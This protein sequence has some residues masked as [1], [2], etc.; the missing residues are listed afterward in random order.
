[1]KWRSGIKHDCSHVMELRRNGADEFQNGLKEIINLEPENLYPMLKSSDLLQDDPIPSR[2]M[3]V[4][5]RSVGENTHRLQKEAPRIWSYL[6]SH[7]KQLDGRRSSIYKRRARFAVFG[8][9]PYSFTPWK[10]AI[11]GFAKRLLFHAVGPHEQ[12]P[13]V[14]D[15]TCYFLPCNTE[16]DAAVLLELLN[17]RAAKGFFDSFV[18]W[19]EKRPITAQLLGSLDLNVLAEECGMSTI[20][21][22]SNPATPDP[23]RLL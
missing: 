5:Q 3:L 22:W 11:S 6:E 19:D 16:D 12:K 8:V 20:P 10:I 13:V 15:D 1:M 21:M 23:I 7:G 4:P 14:L 9:G 18:F 17:S 2:Y